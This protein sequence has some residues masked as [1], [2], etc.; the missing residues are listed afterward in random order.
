MAWMWLSLESENARA[1]TS[2]FIPL[3]ML[4]MRIYTRAVTVRVD[5]AALASVRTRTPLKSQPKRDSINAHVAAS[6]GWFSLV[7]E[8]TL[9]DTLLHWHKV[10]HRC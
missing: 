8:T 10:W 7:R 4:T 9:Q 2:T 6:S 5:S 1:L 3:R